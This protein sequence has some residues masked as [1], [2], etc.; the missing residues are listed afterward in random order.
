MKGMLMT[1]GVMCTHPSW[2]D[3]HENFPFW[4]WQILLRVAFEVVQ[5]YNFCAWF[6]WLLGRNKTNTWPCMWWITKAYFNRGQCPKYKS[7]SV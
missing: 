2:L 6:P 5:R 1:H 4:E 3:N 7:L